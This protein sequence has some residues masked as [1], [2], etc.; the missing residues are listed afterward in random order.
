M[1]L[2]GICILTATLK[3]Q[4]SQRKVNTAMTQFLRC[5]T[6]R[7]DG[8]QCRRMATQELLIV[9]DKALAVLDVCGVCRLLYELRGGEVLRSRKLG[10]CES[11]PGTKFRQA[12][13]TF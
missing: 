2:W 13:V 5:Q 8:K 10:Y 6:T 4:T 9:S 3:N 7:G 12:R 11:H 1:V